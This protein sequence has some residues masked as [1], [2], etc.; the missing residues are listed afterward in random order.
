MQQWLLERRWFPRELLTWRGQEQSTVRT[1]I[2]KLNVEMTITAYS[3]TMDFTLLSDT[4]GAV[5]LDQSPEDVAEGSKI[6]H[7][8]SNR[9]FG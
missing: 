3:T 8:A 5:I 6:I 7:D 1:S 9:H 2:S 4:T